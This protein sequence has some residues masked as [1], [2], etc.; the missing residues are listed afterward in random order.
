VSQGELHA[1]DLAAI[2]NSYTPQHQA[3]LVQLLDKQELLYLLKDTLC[4]DILIP[5]LLPNSPPL[6]DFFTNAVKNSWLLQRVYRFPYVPPGFFAR[7][8]VRLRYLL[9]DTKVC[10]CRNGCHHLS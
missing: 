3:M 8:M 1:D 4:G 2:W 5:G 6:R 10:C 7:L 9:K